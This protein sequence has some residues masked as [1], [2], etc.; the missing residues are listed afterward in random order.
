LRP[1]D[2]RVEDAEGVIPRRFLATLLSLFRG[3]F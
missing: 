3:A 2:G 1:L